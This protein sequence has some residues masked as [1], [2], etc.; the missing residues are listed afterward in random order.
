MVEGLERLTKLK[1]L[2]VENQRLAPGEKLLLDPRTLL[3]LAVRPTPTHTPSCIHHGS[4]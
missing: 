1:E 2:H 4:C 3:C